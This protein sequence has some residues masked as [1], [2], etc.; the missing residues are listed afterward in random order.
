MPANPFAPDDETLGAILIRA[1]T[2]AVVGLSADPQRPSHGVARYLLDQGYRVVPINPKLDQIWGI[3]AYP[4]LEA[5]HADG[6]AIDLVDVFR[7][8]E[9]VAAIAAEAVRIGSPVLWLQEGVVNEEAAR[10]AASAGLTVVMDR[11]IRRTHRALF[12]PAAARSQANV[13][14]HSV[15]SSTAK[16]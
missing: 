15:G 2:I 1:R 8:P 10:S 13:Y 9:A 16:K 4:T 6:H 7:H 5:A 14:P 3:K 11:C 12:G